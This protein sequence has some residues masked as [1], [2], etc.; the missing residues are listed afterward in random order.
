M[1]RLKRA[2]DKK[3]AEGGADQPTIAP[4]P[5]PKGEEKPESEA[6][7]RPRQRVAGL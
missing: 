1:I 5:K 2:K 6:E 4:E 3:Q 7:V